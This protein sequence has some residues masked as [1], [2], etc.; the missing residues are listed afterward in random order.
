[1]IVSSKPGRARRAIS[2]LALAVGAAALAPQAAAA[3]LPPTGDGSG[4]FRLTSI[5]SFNEP[6][7]IVD[8]PGKKDRKLLFVPEQAGRIVVLRNG[9]PQARPFLDISSQVMSGGEE[10]FLSVAYTGVS[11]SGGEPVSFGETRRGVLWV[12]SHAGPI[13]RLDP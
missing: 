3:A 7:E 6:V 2:L 11:V 4:G 12:V 10:G 8:A 13:Y 5:G 1:M 9:A